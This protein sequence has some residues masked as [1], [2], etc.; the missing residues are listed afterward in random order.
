[1]AAVS[2]FRWMM[3]AVLVVSTSLCHAI[4][5]FSQLSS[6]KNQV[7]VAH[8]NLAF[9]ETVDGIDNIGSAPTNITVNKTGFYFLLAAGQAGAVNSMAMADGNQYVDIWFIK[10][11]V[12]VPNSTARITV[13]QF[14]TGTVV[15]QNL[16]HLKENDKLSVGFSASAP[17]FGLVATPSKGNEPAIPSIIFTI[18]KIE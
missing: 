17:G 11:G 8:V 9:L 18:Y 13:G 3:G 2:F 10:N 6:S 7:A 15:I 14:I 12:P 4:P 5:I 1:M 16:M